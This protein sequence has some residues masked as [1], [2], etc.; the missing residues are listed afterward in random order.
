[1]LGLRYQDERVRGALALQAGTYPEANYANEPLALRHLNEANVGLRLAPRLWLDAGIFAAH[2]GSE[3][4]RSLDNLALTRSIMA[5][6]SPYYETGA[7][8]TY[9][10]NARW[11]FTGLVLNGWQNIRDNNQNK[12]L[13]TQIQLKPSARLLL[14]YSTFLGEG[15]N[16]PEPDTRWRHF[17]DL[18]LTWQAT[19]MLK[20][21]AGL[22]V[23]WE[24]TAHKSGEYASWQGG[25]LIARF[26]TTPKT[27]A[28]FRAEYFHDPHG[29]QVATSSPNNLRAL[30][31]SA[32]FDYAPTDR[33][34]LR[35]EAKQYQARDA[36]F[37]T[38]GELW[39]SSTALTALLGVAF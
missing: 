9:E 4:A 28:V 35:F 18:Y 34:L 36:I 33:A 22:D 15:A 24:Q 7:K 21:A 37:P 20:L 23:G 13:G 1:L 39:L 26:Q 27:A 5:D 31:L 11:T 25:Q 14:N 16:R 8:L 3:S 6:N 30:G 10:A 29:V 12:A 2:L 19:T 17:H 38:D 32:G